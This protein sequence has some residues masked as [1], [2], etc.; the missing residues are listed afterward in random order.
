MTGGLGAQADGRWHR[1]I[2][3]LG[4]LSCLPLPGTAASRTGLPRTL[5]LNFRGKNYDKHDCIL[6]G[7]RM[8]HAVGFPQIR[9]CPGGHRPQTSHTASV[10]SD[11]LEPTPW[12]SAPR[13]TPL[14]AGCGPTGCSGP[15][16][17]DLPRA[18][19]LPCA[20]LKVGCVCVK[21]RE[22]ERQR[23]GCAHVC[24]CVQERGR[25][26]QTD[27]QTGSSEVQVRWRSSPGSCFHSTQSDPEPRR[28]LCP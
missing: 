1:A 7:T 8:F 14:S 24:L 12:P 28:G 9:A 19:G 26:S 13:H 3:A 23:K 21:E 20:A 6:P 25:V 5:F 4:A 2:G 27:R 22:R 17:C 18:A 11:R 16:G 10:G 15:G